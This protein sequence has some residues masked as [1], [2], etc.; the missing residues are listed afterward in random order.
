MREPDGER[1]LL[2]DLP[3]T[4][5]YQ[6]PGTPLLRTLASGHAVL[7]TREGN[8]GCTAAGQ[9][10]K[11]IG[12][13]SIIRSENR[14]NKTSLPLRRRLLR[15]SIA[16]LAD[17]GSRFL[18]RR[19]TPTEPPNYYVRTADGK[20]EALTDFKDPTPQCAPSRKNW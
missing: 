19:E 18:T 9:V 10:Q 12:H 13:S 11:A 5:K 16:L 4:K 6:D 7:W 8:C 17:D 3:S 15:D 20:K 2:W 14:E 1:H